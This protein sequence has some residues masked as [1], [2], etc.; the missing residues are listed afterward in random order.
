V[1]PQPGPVRSTSDALLHEPYRFDFFQAVRLLETAARERSE[2]DRRHPSAPV[3]GDAAPG[4]EH[5]R[6]RALPSQAFAPAP[7]SRVAESADRGPAEAVVTFFGM[8]GPQGALPAQY[9][10]QVLRRLRDKD[11]SLRDFLDLFNHRALSLFVRAW[12]K[13]RL[14]FAYERA[15]RAGGTDPVSRVVYCLTGHGTD[16]LRGRQEV[17]DEA[18][19]FYAGHFA[20]RPR[21]AAALEAVLADYFGLP[22]EVQQASGQWLT[23]DD[24]DRS[25]L[26]D[27]DG[28]GLNCELGVSLVVGE[29]VWDVQSKFRLRVG[30]L[31]YAQFRRFMPDGDGLRALVQLTRSFVG[32]DVD[33]DMVPLLRPTE[34]PA[35]VLGG[36]GPDGPRLGWNTWLHEVDATGPLADAVFTGA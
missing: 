14:P 15:A 6:F 3:G 12:E 24:A 16:G 22:V 35:C 28:P 29:R 13:Y 5:V 19:L 4:R 2:H 7:V 8:T 25:R 21:S 23:L 10:S 11:R 33:F 31:T 27:G 18:F 17:P 36:D 26:P 30:P 20:H 9:T 1:P 32:P 34:A